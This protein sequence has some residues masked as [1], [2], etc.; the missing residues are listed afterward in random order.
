MGLLVTIWEKLSRAVSN[1]SSDERLIF[2]GLDLQ[3]GESRSRAGA[4]GPVLFEDSMVDDD[5]VRGVRDFPEIAEEAHDM[6]ESDKRGKPI[7]PEGEREVL[8]TEAP[9]SPPETSGLDLK[10]SSGFGELSLDIFASDELDDDDVDMP[11]DLAE[12]DI[13]ALLMECQSVGERLLGSA[14]DESESRR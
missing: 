3:T 4:G 13:E 12:V 2:S 7:D 11:D 14:R 8:G 10:G 5:R 9:D 6:A 1:D